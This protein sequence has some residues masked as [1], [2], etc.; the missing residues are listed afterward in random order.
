M[1]EG[2]PASLPAED[3]VLV[4]TRLFEAPR[5]LVFSV[6]TKPEHITQW[7]G[8]K[9]FTLPFCE[10]DFRAGGK[11]RFCMRSPENEDFWVWGEYREIV[12][13]ERLV[14]TWLRGE[15]EGEITNDSIVTITLTEHAGKT[16]LTLHQATF[17]T[18]E[19]RDA[20]NGG[21]SECLVRL[22]NY[23]AALASESRS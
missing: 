16:R 17:R 15:P 21:W 10:Q 22:E 18:V 9:D 19:D 14:F 4:L 3:R 7:W 5:E 6:W 23:T 12:P 13:P 2:T 11:Y 1:T 20:H 8:P